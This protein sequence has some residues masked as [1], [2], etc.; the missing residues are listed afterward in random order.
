MAR[1]CCSSEMMQCIL[2]VAT[3]V[4]HHLWGIAADPGHSDAGQLMAAGR[5]LVWI[6]ALH[7][8][9]SGVVCHELTLFMT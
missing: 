2:L 5:H 9:A 1:W 8:G 3:H 6:G 7:G 4:C